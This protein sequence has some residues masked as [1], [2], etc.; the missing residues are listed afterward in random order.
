MNQLPDEFNDEPVVLWLTG[1]AHEIIE[2]TK[3]MEEPGFAFM[4]FDAFYG[5]HYVKLTVTRTNDDD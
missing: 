5:P 1:H 4:A 3:R 2:L